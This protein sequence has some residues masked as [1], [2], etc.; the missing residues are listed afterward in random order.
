M[1]LSTATNHK[2]RLANRMRSI[3][4]SAVYDRPA[5]RDLIARVSEGVWADPALKRCP[6]WVYTALMEV[7]S[8]LAEQIYSHLVWAF[9]GSDGVPRQL[10]DLPEPDRLA[11]FADTLQG[12]H[13]WLKLDRK[14]ETLPDGRIVETI[15]KT[16]TVAKF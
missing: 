2:N 4:A 9:I 6:S 11:V 14:T 16:P 12:G 5:H 15:T 7:R 8:S 1:K 3:Y 10:N 13:Y